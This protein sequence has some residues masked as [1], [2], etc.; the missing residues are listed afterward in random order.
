MP[1]HSTLNA[2]SVLMIFRGVA[3]EGNIHSLGIA[4]HLNTGMDRWMA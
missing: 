4:C 3:S 1:E 2:L